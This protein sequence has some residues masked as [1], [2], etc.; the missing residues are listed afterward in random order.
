MIPINSTSDQ[1][2]VAARQKFAQPTVDITSRRSEGRSDVEHGTELNKIYGNEGSPALTQSLAG[3]S[4]SRRIDEIGWQQPD[5]R[6]ERGPKGLPPPNQLAG[7]GSRGRPSK[8]PSF[9]SD[10]HPFTLTDPSREHKAQR[11]KGVGGSSSNQE[12]TAEPLESS[13]TQIRPGTSGMGSAAGG[14]SEDSPSP[15][16]QPATAEDHPQDEQSDGFSCANQTHNSFGTQQNGSASSLNPASAQA[17]ID[18][19]KEQSRGMIS[20]DGRP[21]LLD[22]EFS[23]LPDF[24]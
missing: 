6:T 17:Y 11:L 16:S 23:I 3:G 14:E 18:A 10:Q 22:R 2:A 5:S 12:S 8:N 15:P 1:Q 21:G 20:S 19:L 24:S 4:Q 7:A 13:S 9:V